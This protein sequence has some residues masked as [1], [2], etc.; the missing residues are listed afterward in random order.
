MKKLLFTIASILV[1]AMASARRADLDKM[2]PFVRGAYY[3]SRIHRGGVA[4]RAVGQEPRVLTAF[5]KVEGDPTVVLSRHGGTVLAGYGGL[6]VARIPIDRLAA[7]SA[8]D[9]V[10]RIEAGQ[11]AAARMDTT[12]I[13]VGAQAVHA[14]MDLPRGY[15]GKGV[16]VGVQDIGFD[17]THPNFYSQDMSRYRIKAMW[18]QLS[19][20]T[21][22]SMLP[23]GRDYVGREALLALGH[24]RDGLTQTHGTHTAGT[25]AGS[26][27]EGPGVLSPYSGIA[28]DSDL[29]LVCN[30][31]SND[32]ELIAPADEYKYTYALDA[33][34]FKYIF[35]YAGREGKPCV[36]NF[37]EGSQEDLHGYDRLY[38]E[39]LDSLCGP[40]R[41]IVASAGN[42]G[43]KINYVHKAPSQPLAGVF[44][45]SQAAMAMATA[46]SHGP[47]A[48][49]LRFYEGA[50]PVVRTIATADVVASADSVWRDSVAVGGLVYAME[51]TAYRSAYDGGELVCDVMVTL[52]QGPMDS[53]AKVALCLVDGSADVEL[54]P[55][56]GYFYHDGLDTT[57]NAGDNSHSINSPSSAP[58]VISVGATA[59]RTHFTNYLGELMVYNNGT[60]GVRTPFS[61][62]GPTW[63]GRTKP[64]VMAPGQNIVS[65]Y[66]TFFINNPANAGY[67]LSSDVRHFSYN[68]RTY[69]WNSN[70]GTSMAAPVVTGIIALWLEADPTLTM[71]D[72]LDIFARS[73]RRYDPSM[74]YPNNYYGY[75]EIDA[76]A[77]MK[78]VLQRT[79]AGVHHVETP[80]Q[81]D[82]RIYSVEGRYVGTDATRLAPGLY[83]RQGRKFVVGR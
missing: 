78:L 23:V 53:G 43:Q 82:S 9:S 27:A 41:I 74:S 72:C 36:I 5:V 58:G 34:G 11:R 1:V 29:C 17:L 57:L 37:S 38:Y 79:A 54:F 8:D 64:D 10:V 68:G 26:G 18:D 45:G 28:Y 21:V 3:A 56:S 14:G 61:A 24:P 32:A 55:V 77:G 35:D 13:V 59:Y 83:I 31:T 42:D 33:L 62:V 81:A 7:L 46:R 49:Q 65:S 12:A 19:A 60:R 52:R 2:S 39:M 16:V 66:S 4:T 50:T 67:P 80:V 22:G 51:A 76:L 71:A 30:V 48:L 75:G 73:C 20:D 25:A 6:C 40:G 70:G 63:D 69:A 15:T 47:F 44:W